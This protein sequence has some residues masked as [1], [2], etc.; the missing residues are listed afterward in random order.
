MSPQPI[1][2]IVLAAGEGSRMRSSIP[3]PLHRLCGRPMVLHVLDALSELGVDR[4]VIVVGFQSVEV[5]KAIETEAPAGLSMSFVEQH[6][7]RGTGDAVAVGLTGFDRESDL[8]EGELLVLPGDAPLVQ[9]E[10]L[11]RLVEVHRAQHAGA[12]LLSAVM[13]DPTGYGRIVRSKSGRVSNIVEHRDATESEREIR[14]VGTSI[15][16]FDLPLLAP[17]LRRI[18]PDNALGEYYLTDV[19]GVLGNVGYSVGSMVVEDAREVAG[20]ND[21]V[22]L[23]VAQETLRDRINSDWMRRGVTMLNP[24]EVYLDTTVELGEEVTLYPNVVLEGN[25]VI[26]SGA[27]IGPDCHLVD[28]TVGECATLRSVDALRAQIGANAE[29]GPFAVLA[30]G[31]SVVDGE[32]TG[33]YFSTVTPF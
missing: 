26:K 6:E 25:T 16:C 10:T 28:T 1:R 14:E 13:D 7:R 4:V 9:P 33:P 5:I 22:Q 23:S 29:V 2:A 17:S 21:R 27:I 3:K 20:V 8:D 12:T 31:T 24:H 18:S 30:P 15:Y 19:I 32:V 11:R